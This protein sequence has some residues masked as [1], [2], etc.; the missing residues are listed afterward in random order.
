MPLGR[1]MDTRPK[2]CP[3]CQVDVTAPGVLCH[4]C[5]TRRW[6][7]SEAKKMTDE[8]CGA[9]N[10]VSLYGLSEE[11]VE[12]VRAISYATVTRILESKR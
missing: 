12:L 7:A 9:Y 1:N 4:G 11:A 2:N 6:I 8:V 5:E 3:D 10:Q